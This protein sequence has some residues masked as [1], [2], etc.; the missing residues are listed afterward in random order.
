MRGRLL[1]VA[2]GLLLPVSLLALWHLAASSGVYTASQ[3]PPPGDVWR[4]GHTLLSRGELGHHV[5]ISAQRVL[6]GF[7]AG[8]FLGLLLGALVGL[9]RPVRAFL[10]PTL[11]ALRAVPSLAWVPLM[12]L[13]LGIGETPKVTLVALGTFFPVFT[14]VAAGLDHLDPRLRELGRAYGR[15][16]VGLLVEVLLPAAAPAIVSGLRLGL[17]QGW[18]FLVAAELIASSMGL[19]YLLVDSQNTGRTDVLLLA[20]VL[21]ALLGKASDACL[22]AVERRVV[23]RWS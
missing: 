2:A 3:L 13:W 19:G 21:L 6:I 7:G 16:G 18:L 15:R 5:A 14:T 4:A 9:F 11:R 17:A 22:G 20:I 10:G 12:L 23:L 8:A 1:R